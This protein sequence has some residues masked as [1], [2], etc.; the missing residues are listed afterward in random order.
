M[1]R[2]ENEADHMW[3]N[4]HHALASAVYFISPIVHFQ[5]AELKSRMCRSLGRSTPL[6]SRKIT[7]SV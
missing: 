4:S 6:F 2:V 7:I 5:A 3:N 1:K